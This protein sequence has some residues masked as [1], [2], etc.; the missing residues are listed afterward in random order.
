[1]ESTEES[2]SKSECEESQ[3]ESQ[4][5]K[6][7]SKSEGDES[8][9]QM[10]PEGFFDGSRKILMATLMRELTDL[11][12]D[13]EAYIMCHIDLKIRAQKGNVVFQSLLRMKEIGIAT[14]TD[15]ITPSDRNILGSDFFAQY[16]SI[17]MILSLGSDQ[18]STSKNYFEALIIPNEQII[19]IPTFKSIVV[20]L[21]GL[22]VA[23][24]EESV[25]AQ[26]ILDALLPKTV[27]IICDILA[28]AELV[29][30]LIEMNG[31]LVDRVNGRASRL[32][33][34]IRF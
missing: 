5:E 12:S 20:S 2:L 33:A 17:P 19:L 27:E 29:Y 8:Q 7:C 30:K 3:D 4:T 1:M 32:Q 16:Q 6:L 11:Q 24:R 25:K 9:Y 28:K 26:D 10:N 22:T 23:T 21:Q 15:L 31:L 18:L 14:N 34:L 13:A